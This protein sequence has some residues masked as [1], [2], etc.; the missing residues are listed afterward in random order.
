MNKEKMNDQKKLSDTKRVIIATKQ[1]SKTTINDNKKVTNQQKDSEVY[2][3][4]SASFVLGY[5]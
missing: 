5:N 3:F 2:D 4:D 1:D